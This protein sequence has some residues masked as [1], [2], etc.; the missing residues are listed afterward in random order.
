MVL[1]LDLILVLDLGLGPWP[2]QPA[3]IPAQTWTKRGSRLLQL[4]TRPRKRL[5]PCAHRSRLEAK[6]RR[7]MLH[8]PATHT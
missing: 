1:D 3:P 7:R 2:S 4:P 6:W 8:G 5:A